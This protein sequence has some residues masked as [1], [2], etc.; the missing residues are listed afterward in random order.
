MRLPPESIWTLEH[1]DNPDNRAPRNLYTS[2][3]TRLFVRR[4]SGC[5]RC[6]RSVHKFILGPSR[7]FSPR[8]TTQASGML[9]KRCSASAFSEWRVSRT[10]R[11]VRWARS[12]RWR[13]GN[14]L[15]IVFLDSELLDLRIQRRRRNAELRGRP[16]RTCDFASALSKSGFNDLLLLTLQNARHLCRRSQRGWMLSREPRFVDRER[17]PSAAT[18]KVHYGRG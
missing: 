10:G 1:D 17:S 5:F 9:R 15:E 6:R 2:H 18:A 14:R 12:A 16:V 7:R 13:L 4:G 8:A 11:G 3:R